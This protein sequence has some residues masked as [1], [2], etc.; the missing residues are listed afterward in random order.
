VPT[1]LR[2]HL[3][4]EYGVEPP[5]GPSSDLPDSTLSQRIQTEPDW[6]IAV[7]GLGRPVSWSRRLRRSLGEVVEGAFTR[8]AAPLFIDSE[9]VRGRVERRKASHTKVLQATIRGI[10]LQDPDVIV[11]GD[12]VI[13]WG[14]NNQ[15]D[16]LRIRAALERGEPANKFMDGLKFVGRCHAPR[17][18]GS[19]SPQDGT[20]VSTYTLS[21]VGFSELDT[22]FYFDLALAS[23]VASSG[24]TQKWMAQIGLN[25]SE[26]FGAGLR[27]AA[28]LRDNAGD[29]IAAMFNL[30]LGKSLPDDVNQGARNATAAAGA[31]ESVQHDL[32]P[33]PQASKEAP[34]A[35]LVPRGVGTALG[36]TVSQA[37][38]DDRVF[39]GLPKTSLEDGIKAMAQWVTKH[40]ARTSGVFEGNEIEKNLPASWAAA[41]KRPAVV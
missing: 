35:Y 18:R 11:P 22:Q 26:L 34:A 13:A 29:L 36:R 23:A 5:A 24:D 33:A 37:S 12:W 7:Y 27:S 2:H 40:G 16:R 9:C 31:A 30:I 41:R 3:V 10:N 14:F 17:K 38:K 20:K 25:F 4:R 32:V 1:V 28:D 8:R 39:G 6:L 19:L 21:A 15:A